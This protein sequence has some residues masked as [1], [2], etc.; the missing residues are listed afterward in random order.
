MTARG[1]VAAAAALFLLLAPACVPAGR[2]PPMPGPDQVVVALYRGSFRGAEGIGGRFRVWLWAEPPDRLHAE[3]VPP[4]GGPAWIVDAGGGRITLAEVATRTAWSGPA[5][6][7]TF[8]TWIGVP[9]SPD[10]FVRAVTDGIPSTDRLDAR[11][12]PERGPGLPKRLELRGTGSRLSLD[13]KGFATAPRGTL[14]TGQA[15]PG[16]EIRPLEDLEGRAF[17]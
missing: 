12:V 6:D 10:T 3:I 15:P 17:R 2:R 8:E 4:F 9:I 5:S 16:F 13:R 11:R 14:G 7:R 1:R